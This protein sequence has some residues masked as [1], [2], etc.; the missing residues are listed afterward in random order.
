MKEKFIKFPQ[1]HQRPSK[2]E[3]RGKVYSKYHNSLNHGTN[4][5]W[6]FRNIIQNRINKGILKFLEKKRGHGD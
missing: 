3:L 2:E 6:S 5:Y 4:S 1:D